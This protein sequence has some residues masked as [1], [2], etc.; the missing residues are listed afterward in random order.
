MPPNEHRSVLQ[1]V[2][3]VFDWLELK[4]ATSVIAYDG[5]RRYGLIQALD[6]QLL[7]TTYHGAERLNHFQH[8][9]EKLHLLADPEFWSISIIVLVII[10]SL[11]LLSLVISIVW[12]I[13][14]RRRIRRRAAKIGLQSLPIPQQLHMARQLGFFEDMYELLQT[15]RIARAP[16]MTA[17]EFSGSL[18]YLPTEAYKLVDQMT[19][20]FYR[21]RYGGANVPADQ[22]KRLAT[23]VVRLAEHL[24]R[25][26]GKTQ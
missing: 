2:R 4:W 20:I 18:I 25:A 13:I 7:R 22:Q 15:H 21:V 26:G 5:T 14:E 9:W 11:V 16:H 23:A 1:R 17:R 19:R 12:F 10:I 8:W 3:H 6:S 24:G